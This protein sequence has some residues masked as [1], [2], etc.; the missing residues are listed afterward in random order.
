[1]TLNILGKTLSSAPTTSSDT[2]LGEVIHGYVQSAG[3]LA[4]NSFPLKTRLADIA[5]LHYVD[6]P[7]MYRNA[8]YSASRP[9]WIL[10][11]DLEHKMSSSHRWND[12]VSTSQI[13]SF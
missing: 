4:S 1:M 10:D 2:H 11:N 5:N 6:G 13:L 8:P 9:W 12:T 7:P 3:T